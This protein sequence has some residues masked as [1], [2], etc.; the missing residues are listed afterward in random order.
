MIRYHYELQAFSA[1]GQM[2]SAPPVI[3]RPRQHQTRK[4][5]QTALRILSSK[6]TR[7]QTGKSRTIIRRLLYSIIRHQEASVQHHHT[8]GGVCTALSGIIRH[9]WTA[10]DTQIE[11]DS[12]RHHWTASDTLRY[13]LL[14]QSPHRLKIQIHRDNPHTSHPRG[15]WPT[16]PSP[17]LAFGRSDWPLPIWWCGHRGGCEGCCA[18]GLGFSGSAD[19]VLACHRRFGSSNKMKI[20]CH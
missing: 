18:G 14:L 10:S 13:S 19:P 1:S 15:A 5:R 16:S 6:G 4:S 20:P 9:H 8:S 12:I 17:I 2:E 3:T 11:T 7:K